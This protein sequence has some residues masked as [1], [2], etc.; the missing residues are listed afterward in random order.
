MSSWSR[1]LMTK[2]I[3]KFEHLTL[4]SVRV[5]IYYTKSEEK[6]QSRLI[7][8]AKDKWSKVFSIWTCLMNLHRSLKSKTVVIRLERLQF[9]PWLI[10][11][12]TVRSSGST[13]SWWN[14]R[15]FSNLKNVVINFFLS[16]IWKHKLLQS[17]VSVQIHPLGPFI[18]NIQQRFFLSCFLIKNIESS[19][20]AF[21][22][23]LFVSEW[24][25]ET[26]G[27][28]HLL[29]IYIM[30]LQV[31]YLFSVDN[32]FVYSKFLAP[33]FL[34][35]IQ[36]HKVFLNSS[37]LNTLTYGKNLSSR[38]RKKIDFISFYSIFL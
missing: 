14:T 32:L 10:R 23:S 18:F 13:Y 22:V 4:I 12:T 25:F 8:Y 36:W 29:C 1:L 34:I 3:F 26:G 31:F 7:C 24:V 17:L 5:L 27:D 15:L 19:S 6:Q 38:N 9:F 16:L 30:V 37:W 11:P 20:C 28:T 35:L 21:L 2:L 33:T